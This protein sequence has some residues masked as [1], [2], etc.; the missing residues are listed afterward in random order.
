MKIFL[1]GTCLQ[2]S[3]DFDYRKL[4]I[5]QLEQ[6]NIDYFNPVVDEWDEDQ[7]QLE[8]QEKLDCDIHLYVITPNTKGVYS[9]AE[10]FASAIQGAKSIFVYIKNVA[11]LE[12]DTCVLKSVVA[13]S[14]LFVEQ[15]DYGYRCSS[16]ELNTELDIDENFIQDV[17]L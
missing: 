11:G 13:T 2:S 16:W 14:H 6:N 15:C 17:L 8:E 1:G 7:R 3:N 12:F 4:L 10:A 9:I 5:P